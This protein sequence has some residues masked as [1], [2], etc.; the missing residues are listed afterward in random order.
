MIVNPNIYKSGG[1]DLSK[2]TVTVDDM[3]EG[4]TAYD[5]VGELI[6]GAVPKTAKGERFANTKNLSDAVV[7]T[8]SEPGTFDSTFRVRLRVSEIHAFEKYALIDGDTQKYKFGDATADDV[9]AGKT[10]TSKAGI[11]VT[12]KAALSGKTAFLKVYEGISDGV[13]VDARTKETVEIEKGQYVGFY[14]GTTLVF[15][16]NTMTENTTYLWY[17]DVTDNRNICVCVGQSVLSN[18]SLAQYPQSSGYANAIAIPLSIGYT[19][20]MST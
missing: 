19:D 4:V 11:K 1:V 8:I 2:A 7:C 9:L 6:T 14:P 16:N 18:A 10:F 12:G 13:W 3:V 17:P 5:A 15:F 20:F